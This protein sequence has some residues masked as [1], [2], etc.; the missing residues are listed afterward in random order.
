[1]T[2]SNVDAV[3]QE[4]LDRDDQILRLRE[5]GGSYLAIAERLGLERA[6]VARSGYLRALRRLPPDE[7]GAP[8]LRELQRLDSLANYIASRDDIDEAA[9]ARQLQMIV[10]L[11]LDLHEQ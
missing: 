1:M 5:S 6:T 8:R 9:I 10:R 4:G 3:V 7:R 2:Q 11:R